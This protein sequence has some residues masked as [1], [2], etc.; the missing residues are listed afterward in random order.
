MPAHAI[1]PV[2]AALDEGAESSLRRLCD[3]LR[4]PSISTDPAHGADCR[5][6]AEWCVAQLNEIGITAKVHPTKGQPMVLGHAPC[7]AKDDLGREKMHVL[8]YG[9]YDVQPADPLDEWENPPFEPRFAKDE[10]NGNVVKARGASDDKGQL[11]TF[12]EACR[13]W[14]QAHGELPI[15][16]TVLL[17]GEEESGSPS[18][19]AFLDAK[20]D[21]LTADIALVCDTGQWNRHTPAITTMLRGLA[22]SEVV[23]TG[24]SR[25]LHSGMYGGPAQNPIKVL[26]R[27]IAELQ[28]SMGRI[29]V[30]GFYS[31]V[32]EPSLGLLGQWRSLGFDAPG[33]L[34]EVGLSRPAGE[35]GRSVLEQLWSR[36]TAEVNGIIGGYTG[37]G[38]KTVIPSK[39]SAKFSFRLVPGQDPAKVLANFRRFVESLLPPDCSAEFKGEHGSPAVGFDIHAP[40]FQAAAE[41][42][43]EEWGRR[44]ALMGCGGSIPIV[45]SF[46]SE[47]GMDALLMGFALDDD[48]I[49]SPNEKYNLESY[50]RGARSWA[51][52]LGK[53]AEL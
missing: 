17:E 39:A 42:L 51:R 14:K 37:P 10:Q 9:H 53:L 30:P 23:I 41:A 6:A 38:S 13:A 52:L 26:S 33:F 5:K 28:D 40:V 36:P 25:D 12:L 21:A 16:V 4:I 2:L 31:G 44:P 11:M 45:E 8:F 19:P 7:K 50:H 18:L 27:I 29:Q 22:F 34:G 1:E 48:R 46:K 35:H 47:L 3:F 32:R 15:A 20:R 43:E 24:P 49:H